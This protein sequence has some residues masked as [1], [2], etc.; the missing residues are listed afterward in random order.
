[1]LNITRLP[2]RKIR[3]SD[4]VP[5]VLRSFPL[6]QAN[7]LHPA[8]QRRY[9][10]GVILHI[11]I[12]LVF[13]FQL[14]RLPFRLANKI[15]PCRD[16]FKPGFNVFAK[17]PFQWIIR[18]GGSDGNGKM[19]ECCLFAFWG[20]S[21]GDCVL[22]AGF[23][24]RACFCDLR[25]VSVEFMACCRCFYSARLIFSGELHRLHWLHWQHVRQCIPELPIKG[26]WQFLCGLKIQLTP[27]S[28]HLHRF[29]RLNHVLVLLA[30]HLGNLQTCG[31]G[32]PVVDLDSCRAATVNRHWR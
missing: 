23:T 27:F 20:C 9:A 4:C 13:V 14:H 10:V 28:R 19:W 15:V 16:F 17:T 1:M 3:T 26:R 22:R 30:E 11:I 6:R 7:K 25:R 8:S 24:E 12:K 31:N 21:G 5:N 29:N 18:S 32:F 2:G